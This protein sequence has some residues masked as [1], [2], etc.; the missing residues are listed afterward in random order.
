[1]EPGDQS[2]APRQAAPVELLVLNGRQKGA[3]RS[4]DGAMTLL[5]RDPDCDLR[6]NVEEVEPFHCAIAGGPDEVKLRDLNSARGTFV[7]GQ[8]IRVALL[9]DGDLLDVG[10]FRFRVLLPAFSASSAPEMPP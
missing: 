1:M 10:P 8:R 7:N 2:R 4:L 5:G 9:R 6:L 3:R